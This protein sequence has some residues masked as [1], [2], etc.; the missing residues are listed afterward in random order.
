[1]ILQRFRAA[2][3]LG[4]VACALAVSALAAEPAK[5]AATP[6]TFTLAVIPDTQNYVDWTHQ[7][8]AG[9]PFDGKDMFLDQLRFVAG[10]T[11]SQG[12]DIAF[13]TAVGDVWQH[14]TLKMDPDHA[15]RGLARVDNPIMDTYFAPTPKA[16]SVEAA[17]AREGYEILA[18]KAP[19][20]V[21]PGN[22][23]YDA[24]WTDSRHPAAAAY[25][26]KNPLSL[27]VLHP[28]G[29]DNWRSVFGEK[30]P[31]FAGKPWYVG[32][33]NGGADSAQI[34][35]AGGYRFLHIGLEMAAPDD[36]LAWATKVINAHPGLPVIVS[37][38][39]HMDNTA[40]RQPNPQV[41]MKAV[42]PIHNNPEDVWTKFLSQNDRIFLVLSGHQHG[43]AY[44]VDPNV[45]GHKVYQLLSD[46]QDRGQSAIQA[47]GYKPQ[48]YP[49]MV[50]DGWLRLMS[51]DMGV[52][53]PSIR[54]RTY[55]THYKAFSSEVADY[56]KWYKP[57][58]APMA[59]D[60]AFLARDE[61][62]IPLD[63]FRARFGAPK[64]R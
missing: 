40:T 12:G 8:V 33:Y 26:P 41:D 2:L 59:T 14:Q 53:T 4:A 13:V 56:A 28:G 48:G 29:L 57:H 25:D 49:P 30:S 45:K 31:F 38:H 32:A 50:G 1:M 60:E 24:M 43:Q 52:A 44:R 23:D 16:L 47:P 17:S 37:T 61:F 6:T 51:F 19:F 27:G 54:V 10:R 58:E 46:Y 35:T 39:D 11:V 3:A 64:T 63:D 55:S 7:K 62:T 9:Y 15:A 18:G 34:F 22:H 20:S 36:V 5:V 42:D 21:V